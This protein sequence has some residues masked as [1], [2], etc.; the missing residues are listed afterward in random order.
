MEMAMFIF[1]LIGAVFV[2]ALIVAIGAYYYGKVKEKN[3]VAE[4]NL[5][6]SEKVT[7]TAEAIINRK[8]GDGVANLRKLQQDKRK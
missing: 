6:A 2:L 4:A 3:K 1:G 7:E 8:R 5:E